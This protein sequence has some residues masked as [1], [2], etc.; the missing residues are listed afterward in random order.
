MRKSGSTEGHSALVVSVLTAGIFSN[1][2]ERVWRITITNNK[3]RKLK[4]CVDSMMSPI[5]NL[6]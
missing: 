3:K 6:N 4:L 5:G 2:G 1:Y